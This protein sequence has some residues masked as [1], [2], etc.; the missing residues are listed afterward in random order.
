[1]ISMSEA[2]AHIR[3]VAP[4]LG[5]EPIEL[6]HAA[7]RRLAK[8]LHADIAMPPFKS[9]SMDGYAISSC[10]PGD[11]LKLIGESAAGLPF[12]GNVNK[13][14]TI[15][16]S[17]GAALPQGT[18]RILIQE[19]ATINKNMVV[20]NISPKIGAYVRQ[21]GSDFEV[22][23][24]LLSRGIKLGAAQLA[25]A[26]AANHTHLSV[27]KQPRVALIS[28]G[29]ELKQIGSELSKG[30]I[31]AANAFGLKASLENWGANVLDLGVVRDDLSQI[32]LLIEELSDFDIIIPV[33]GASIGDHDLMRPAFRNAGF[34]IIFQR[35]A[36]R[37]GKPCWLAKNG[38][39]IVLGLPGNP[40][41]ALVCAHLFIR[42][43]MKLTNTSHTL[44][45][46]KD[47]P[48]NGPRECYLRGKV[49]I[50]NGKLF[51]TPFCQQESFRL[52]PQSN[53]N[54]LI[55]IPPLGGPYAAGD[56]LDV[57]SF[58]DEDFLW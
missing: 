55:R 11:K 4:N 34:D 14:E 12:D 41:S 45:I 5:V 3:A 48:E 8:D 31:I 2:L 51:V 29:N 21:A 6:A 16:I 49:N 35:I 42:P 44:A 52:R 17:T 33:G 23:D 58:G 24:L 20:A 37:P 26:A 39:Q 57:V 13:G 30:E 1:M 40:A 10:L 43:L 38:H 15:R 56:K 25:L 54:A 19:N 28:S 46:T 47:I 32:E 53:A 7:K 50:E 9:S 27:R 36:M 18:D 22:G